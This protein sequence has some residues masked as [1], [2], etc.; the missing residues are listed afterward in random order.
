MIHF[1]FWYKSFIIESCLVAFSFVFLSGSLYEQGVLLLHLTKGAGLGS[2]L[3]PFSMYFALKIALHCIDIF[4]SFLRSVF[5]FKELDYQFLCLFRKLCVGS[6]DIDWPV[7][8][9][10]INEDVKSIYIDKLEKYLSV[11]HLSIFMIGLLVSSFYYKTAFFILYS[12][13]IFILCWIQSSWIKVDFKTTRECIALKRQGLI[14]WLN[15]YGRSAFALRWCWAGKVG[16]DRWARS[17]SGSLLDSQM[18]LLRQLFHFNMLQQAFIEGPY[19][20]LLLLSFLLVFFHRMSLPVA[21]AWSGSGQYLISCAKNMSANAARVQSIAA[22]HRV[23]AQFFSI[24]W[25]GGTIDAAMQERIKRLFSCVEQMHCRGVLQ[26]FGNNGVGKSTLLNQLLMKLFSQDQCVRL[27]CRVLDRESR[28][29][30]CIETVEGQIFGPNIATASNLSQ[31][32]LLHL[33]E[34]V[35]PQP[36]ILAWAQQFHVLFTE[37]ANGNTDLSSGQC[38]VLSVARLFYNW[39]ASVNIIVVDECDAVLDSGLR[40]LFIKTVLF[41]A[42]KCLCLIVS[43]QLDYTAYVVGSG[44]RFFLE[45]TAH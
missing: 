34:P 4:L 25:L 44:Y 2:L 36:L 38:I 24:K 10:I 8:Y 15:E 23:V 30:S 43:H 11:S 28:F 20:G 5:I 39:N 9:K 41:L 42:K 35:L 17:K 29:F 32:Q 1:K 3:L 12:M 13:L 26:V 6:F 22:H 14:T 18:G 19:L 33:L 45:D 31:Q 7:F 40:W 27:T 37:Y 16:F 21:L